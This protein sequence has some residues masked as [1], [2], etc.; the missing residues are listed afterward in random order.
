[1]N[2]LVWRFSGFEYSQHGGLW[3]DG[4]QIPVGP[5][6]RQLLELLLECNGAVVSKAEISER[7]WPGRPVSDDSIDRCAYLLRKPLKAAGAGDRIATAYGRGLSLRALVETLDPESH[8]GRASECKVD[9]HTLDLWQTAHE[10]AG[11]LTGDGFAR[12][13]DAVLAAGAQNEFSPALWSL[14]AHIAAS[15]VT[16]GYLRPADGLEIIERDAGR[17][18]TLSPDFL[19]AVSVLGWARATLDARP[20]EGV[21]MLDRV[22]ARDPFYSKA[23]AHR[24]WARV[25]LSQLDGAIEDMDEA[26]RVSPHDR[27]HLSMRAWLAFCAGDIDGSE[28]LADDG[29]QVRPDAVGLHCVRAMAASLSGRHAE[30]ETASRDGLQRAPDNP[31]A[32]AVLAY[33]LARAGRMEEAEATLSALCADDALAPPQLFVSAAQLAL[34]Q[35]DTAEG[36]LRGG[37][38]EGCP[39]IAFAPFDPRLEPLRGHIDLMSRKA[40]AG[41]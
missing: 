1:M 9:C 12:A 5:Q 11:S 27:T 3:K 6:A 22:V 30:A 35:A 31:I 19:P 7:L 39:W 36:S 18:L 34:G 20:E 37:L 26:L 16:I 17:A 23:L 10:L 24:S 13:Q 33:V 40:D 41:G 21:E 8:K 14:S 2:G 15:R 32:A 28:R 29:L 4:V 25:G 38:E